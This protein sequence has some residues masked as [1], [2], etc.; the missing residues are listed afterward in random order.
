MTLRIRHV[1]AANPSP[2]TG[3]GTNTWI[4]GTGRVAVIDPGPALEDHLTAILDALTPGEVISH[5]VVTHA[6]LDHSALALPLAARTGAPVLAF[7][8]A[9]SGRSAAMSTL[10][11]QGFTSGGEGADLSFRPDAVLGDGDRIMGGDWS[12]V[13]VHTP[14]HMGGHLCLD[15]G[16][17]LFSGDHVMGWSST[18]VSPPDGDMGDYMASLERLSRGNWTRLLPGHGDPVEDPAARIAELASH[19]REREAQILDALRHGPG[20]ADTLTRRIYRGIP[21]A[22]LP[23]AR[24]NVLAHLIDLAGRNQVYPDGALA[25]DSIFHRM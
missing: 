20:T 3:D 10:V 1:R 19:R 24:R 12:L 22:L 6:H 13:A 23:A 2:L 16:D 18:I 17:V 11:A 21:P 25:A 9:A 5:I 14:G 7:G 4:V 8:D 15:A